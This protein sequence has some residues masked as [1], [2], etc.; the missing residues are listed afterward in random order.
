MS[1]RGSRSA[2]AATRGVSS[3]SGFLGR[4]IAGHYPESRT[5]SGRVS[6]RSQPRGSGNRGAD[7]IDA[8][9]LAPHSHV[10]RKEYSFPK[11]TDI[12][13]KGAFPHVLEV[14]P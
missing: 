1:P 7:S 9:T 12:C 10:W 2:L 3:L 8:C 11:V 4:S 5:G 13:P 14:T 6:R